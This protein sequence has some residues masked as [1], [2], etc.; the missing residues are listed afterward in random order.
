MLD[1]FT[2]LT[3]LL[4]FLVEALLEDLKNSLVFS[5][6]D[7]AFFAG[8]AAI[9]DGASLRRIGPIALQRQHFYF[10]GKVKHLAFT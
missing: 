9:P 6:C 7:P 5:A 3:H 2:P 1:C 8:R 4:R 10:N